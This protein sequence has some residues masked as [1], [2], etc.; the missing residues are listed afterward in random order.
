MLLK[1]EGKDVPEKYRHL[2]E[3]QSFSNNHRV[4]KQTSEQ[5]ECDMVI[6]VL[7]DEAEQ[8]VIGTISFFKDCRHVTQARFGDIAAGR[9]DFMCNE[10]IV[11][12]KYRG[13]TLYFKELI[14]KSARDIKDNYAGWIL[15][16]V[17]ARRIK[18][19]L[20]HIL[21]VLMARGDLENL[22]VH[23]VSSWQS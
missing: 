6:Y 19:R 22:I 14:V 8:E 7:T 12:E 17:F 18:R 15:Q 10:L 16:C 1:I 13:T 20:K 4:T 21:D 5:F 23:E 11:E 2:L 3:F 9:C